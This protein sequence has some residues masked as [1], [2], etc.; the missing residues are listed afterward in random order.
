MTVCP[1]ELTLSKAF[2]F[3]S[4]CYPRIARAIPDLLWAWTTGLGKSISLFSVL[5]CFTR[6]NVT[7]Q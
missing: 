2:D 4:L 6:E 7:G 1:A 5:L 3:E